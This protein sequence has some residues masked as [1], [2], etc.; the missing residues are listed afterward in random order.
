MNKIEECAK[1]EEEKPSEVAETEKLATD[2]KGDQENK[3]S[4]GDKKDVETPKNLTEQ[5]SVPIPEESKT[6]PNTEDQDTHPKPN[7]PKA[8][9]PS[10]VDEVPEKVGPTSE[11]PSQTENKE[12]E[13][14][15]VEI[16][17]QSPAPTETKKDV[18][19]EENAIATEV[20]LVTL[21]VSTAQEPSQQD[22]APAEGEKHDQ[23]LE[24]S[25]SIQEEC[26]VME[27]PT[28]V[29][30]SQENSKEQQQTNSL[31]KIE[32]TEEHKDDRVEEKP[33]VEPTEESVITEVKE[34]PTEES[35]IT[36]KLEEKPNVEPTEVEE[37][38]TAEL[39]EESNIVQELEE[40]PTE[41]IKE[42]VSTEELE[43][44]PTVE[45]KEI[46]STEELEE[47]ST[48]EHTEESNVTEV[49]VKPTVELT[50]ECS[51]IEV[52]EK[53]YEDPTVEVD[54]KPTEKGIITD[55]VHEEQVEEKLAEEPKEELKEEQ[56]AD[57]YNSEEKYEIKEQIKECKS[58][59]I[60][61]EKQKEEEIVTQTNGETYEEK[62]NESDNTVSKKPLSESNVEEIQQEQVTSENGV[63]N[64]TDIQIIGEPACDISETRS[65]AT[66]P[67]T[68]VWEQ[69]G[70][71]VGVSGTFNNWNDPWKLSENEGKFSL[72]KD[73]LEGEYLYKFIVDDNWTVDA[74]QPVA[75]TEEHG[76]VNV[77]KI[78]PPVSQE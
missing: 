34:K 4:D 54:G 23:T 43:E 64:G 16:K 58:Q 56:P 62:T 31:E 59:D 73:L 10:S 11:L 66:F 35:S 49:V 76:Q 12:P 36:E 21:D 5:F 14:L 25:P 33:T 55:E 60:E 37:K 17:A 15:V 40:K 27:K 13:K 26:E 41:E 45:I 8:T 1:V 67:A 29:S 50:D 48:A 78:Q 51:S 72:T 57:T 24:D 74:S 7:E 39:T 71:E 68:F 44:K 47:K 9:E 42:T 6:Q 75:Q 22:K 19:T 61:E 65:K 30:I 70:K 77:M 20:P 63:Q 28:E 69:E 38:P 32:I 46:I 2:S 53:S 18:T 3:E 52:E